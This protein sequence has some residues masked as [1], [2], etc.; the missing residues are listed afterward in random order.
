MFKI[1]MK[2]LKFSIGMKNIKKISLIILALFILAPV[3][4][5]AHQPRIPVGNDITVS[6]PEISKAFY[7]KLSGDPQ[8]YHIDSALP[9]AF[10]VNILVPDISGQKKDVSVLISKIDG[11][12]SKIVKYLDGKNA[13]WKKFFE[14]FG[15]DTYWM[16]PEYS[17]QAEAGEY[18]IH[19]ISPDFDSKYSLAIGE[20]EKFDLKE[21][22]N[23]INLI[24]KIKRDFF[25]ESPIN[26]ILSPFGWGYI[27]LMYIFAFIFGF[28]YRLI[29]KRINRN[30]ISGVGK[31]INKKDRLIRAIFGVG[32]LFLAIT[33]SWNPILIFFSGFCIFEAIFSWCGLY[34]A[35]GK[36]TCPIE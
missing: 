9:F 24:P 4:A 32:L 10:Y 33:T 21:S 2:N 30:K 35:L 29:M 16:G 12:N 19:V 34:A 3:L 7:S 28:L 14:P 13:E 36:N 23:A 1:I 18:V 8:I 11:S 22:M 26:F 15:H 6:D 31:N 17:A 20:A 5:H 25:N 27:L